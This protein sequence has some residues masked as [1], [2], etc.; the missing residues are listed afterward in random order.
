MFN[1]FDKKNKVDVEFQNSKFIM[2]IKDAK[3]TFDVFYTR[4]IIVI[5]S[6]DMFK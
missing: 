4:F 5:T 6:L 1:D 2:R 3:K